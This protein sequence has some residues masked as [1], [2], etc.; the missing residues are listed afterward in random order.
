MTGA[1]PSSLRDARAVE[2]RG[3]HQELQIVAQALLH[4]ERQRQPKIGIERALVEFVEQQRRDAVERRIVEHHAGEHALGHDLDAG[5]PRHLRAEAHAVADGLP[6][7]LPKRRRHAR[8]GGARREPARLQH[9][10]LLVL[11]P[12]LVARA[13]AARASSCRRRAARPAP[14]RCASRSAAVSAGSASSIGSAGV[15]AAVVNAGLIKP[16]APFLIG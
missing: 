13:P 12:R 5:R 9:D 16:L 2:R 7:L 11:R 1:S 3:H 10:D 4:V 6:D 14:P 8:R 15:K